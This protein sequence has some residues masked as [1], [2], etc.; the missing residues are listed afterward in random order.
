MRAPVPVS[1]LPQLRYGHQLTLWRRRDCCLTASHIRLQA[2]VP[3][4]H[5][6]RQYCSDRSAA[7]PVLGRM[8]H[9][10][11]RNVGNKMLVR[12]VCGTSHHS[13]KTLHN[14]HMSKNHSS[15]C[16]HFCMLHSP[17]RCLRSIAPRSRNPRR[18]Q[19]RSRRKR[20]KRAGSRQSAAL[21]HCNRTPQ[22]PVRKSHGCICQCSTWS[23]S[24]WSSRHKAEG[25][26]QRRCP[27]HSQHC[28]PV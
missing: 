17:G 15:C 7:K 19:D 4:Q 24:L 10:I 18:T 16:V 21:F 22:H 20:C 23:W 6:Q 8:L 1:R 12:P 13:G 25:P 3:V 9:K 11:H 2:A 26:H 14:F 27:H 5:S 28:T